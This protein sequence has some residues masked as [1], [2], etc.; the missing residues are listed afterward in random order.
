MRILQRTTST[1]GRTEMVSELKHLWLCTEEIN[2]GTLEVVNVF[3]PAIFVD[4]VVKLVE[5]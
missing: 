3:Q 2:E 1:C 4:P 5:F